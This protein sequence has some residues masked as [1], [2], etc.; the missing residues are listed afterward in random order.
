MGNRGPS[1]REQHHQR[2]AE[3]KRPTIDPANK[4]AINRENAM[5][6]REKADTPKEIAARDHSVPDQGGGE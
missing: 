1:Q 2:A 6:E 4:L 5:I 3:M